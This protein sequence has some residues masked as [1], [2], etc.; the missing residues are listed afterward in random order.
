MTFAWIERHRE[1]FPVRAMCETLG[2]SPSGFYAARTRQPGPR[3]QQR[4]EQR[5]QVVKSFDG[6]R[7]TY[8]SPRVFL[9]LE[10]RG[11]RICENTVAR[12][13]RGN[14]LR[15]KRRRKFVPR[16]TDAKHAFPIAE[17]LLDRAFKADAPNRKWVTDITYIETG[18]GWLYVAA[19]LDLYSR[20]IVGWS[21]A[22]HMRVDLVDG[23][24]SMALARRKPGPGLLHH[25]D[26]GVQYACSGYQQKLK[27]QGI[28]CSM[29]RTGNCYDNAAME[30][31]WSTLK[32]E[33]VYHEKFATR[34]AAKKAIFEYVEVFYNRQ[35]KHSSI[36]FISPEAFE[37]ALN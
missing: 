32:T 28:L 6:S 29:S 2:V 15:S 4:E 34:E 33:L 35:R 26:R 14:Q 31:F 25:S 20:K 11:V 3:Q 19:V 9:E 13:M 7:G 10:A 16:T 22:D 23:A 17:N 18:E 12:I 27:D 37:A 36:G 5:R 1:A 30:S 24:L 8:G 21:M